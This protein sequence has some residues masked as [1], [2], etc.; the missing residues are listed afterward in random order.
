MSLD[1]FFCLI[2]SGY[3]AQTWE[4]EVDG[5]SMCCAYFKAPRSHIQSR[6]TMFAH[7]C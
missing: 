7:F 6:E 1:A 2:N 5:A 3:G 4:E